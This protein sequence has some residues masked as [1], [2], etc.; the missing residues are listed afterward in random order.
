[1]A[2]R[3]PDR[4]VRMIGI[5][6]FLERRGEATFAELAEHFGTTTRQISRDIDLLWVTGA[7]GYSHLD[8]IDFD[9]SAYEQGVALL[10]N[11]QRL[12]RPLRLAS[13]EAVVLVASLRALRESYGPALLEAGAQA[14]DSALA[15]LVAATGEAAAA[16]D[17]RLA[18]DG[19]PEVVTEVGRALT[20]RR[21]LQLRYV[22]GADVTSDRVVDPI[23]LLTEEDHSYL[24]AWCHRAQDERTFRL[25][26]ILGAEVLDADAAARPAT[27]SSAAPAG[28]TSAPT[29]SDAGVVRVRLAGRARYVV[30]SVPVLDLRNEDDGTVT[31]TLAVTNPAWW[32]GLLLAHATDVLEVV[33]GAAAG[34]AAAAARGALAAYGVDAGTPRPR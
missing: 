9:V 28:A 30:D 3:A 7:P 24:L 18:V 29:G 26:R 32:H 13:R 11:A 21:Q 5:L 1:M 2:E 12:D 15:K 33:P 17:L 31:A 4:V 27:R 10:R 8:L 19:A 22:T 16:V 14:V 34:P 25:D 6:A 20:S 23:A